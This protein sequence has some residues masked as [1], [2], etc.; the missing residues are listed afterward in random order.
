MIKNINYYEDFDSL[1]FEIENIGECHLEDPK[2][3]LETKCSHNIFNYEK[4]NRGITDGYDI[5]KCKIC[6]CEM[7]RYQ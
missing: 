1:S 5:I 3:N 6:G 7:K 2:N 4:K